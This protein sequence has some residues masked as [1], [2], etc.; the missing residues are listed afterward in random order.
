MGE[1]SASGLSFNYKAKWEQK[2][3]KEVRERWSKKCLRLSSQAPTRQT[4]HEKPVLIFDFLAGESKGVKR[5]MRE[6]GAATV[7]ILTPKQYADPVEFP[8]EVFLEL[9]DGWEPQHNAMT[10]RSRA[11][12]KPHLS[13]C[14]LK[15]K[16][17]GGN[18]AMLPMQDHVKGAC[19]RQAKVQDPGSNWSV[20]H[21][22][23][24]TF[25]GAC[26]EQFESSSKRCCNAK[27]ASKKIKF[28][29]L[30]P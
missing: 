29:H 4:R 9:P 28:C 7:G 23:Q 19:P 11:L 24:T 30:L 27:P 14:S 10:Q 12:R 15:M 8:R 5:E 16:R 1:S 21:R 2:N 20:T 17:F 6:M 26:D 22:Y 18:W 13:S 25:T 3:E